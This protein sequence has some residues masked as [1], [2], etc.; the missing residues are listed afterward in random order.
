MV[1]AA[2]ANAA[3]SLSLAL[4]ISS[5]LGAAIATTTVCSDSAWK[6]YHYG[7]KASLRFDV[8]R[9]GPESI[10]TGVKEFAAQNNLSYSSVGS[11][12]PY[13][14]PPLE[15][16]E[17]IL[18][19]TSVAIVI[20]VATSNRSTIARS[21]IE[22]FSF[23]CGPVTKDWRP[24]WRAFTAFLRANGYRLTPDQAPGGLAAP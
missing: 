24:Y 23:S 16:L 4:L 19:D 20:T 14:H 21:T 5:H 8:G 2:N 22:T 17:Q 1:S 10:T 15:T 7:Q 12:N 13:K 18:Q 3:L 6:Q 9:A 11:H